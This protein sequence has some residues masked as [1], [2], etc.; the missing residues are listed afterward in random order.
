[1]LGRGGDRQLREVSSSVLPRQ[2]VP[3]SSIILTNSANLSKPT[4]TANFRLFVVNLPQTLCQP[5]L[6]QPSSPSPP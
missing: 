1:M 4:I 2:F 6:G 5:I 3:E